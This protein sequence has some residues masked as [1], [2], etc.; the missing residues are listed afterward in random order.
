MNGQRGGALI[1]LGLRMFGIAFVLD[2]LRH[3]MPPVPVITPLM[4]TV[5]TVLVFGAVVNLVVYF[6]W[7]WGGR[8][9]REYQAVT[10]KLEEYRGPDLT[11][12]ELARFRKDLDQAVAA[13]RQLTQ[14]A[15][16]IRQ[17]ML[18]SSLSINGVSLNGLLPDEQL[19][20]LSGEA[21]IEPVLGSLRY[22]GPPPSFMLTG[23]GPQRKLGQCILCTTMTS[24]IYSG[25]GP[26][27][28]MCDL[29]ARQ[30]RP[31]RPCLACGEES[32][33]VIGGPEPQYLCTWH[34]NHL[35][36]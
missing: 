28:Y 9:E 19:A 17:G 6:A 21:V 22:V 27:Y 15:Q 7:N 23:T 30:Q 33:V 36:A 11:S 16:V 2:V 31:L 18:G 24:G 32:D 20:V 35:G 8:G 5:S 4:H 13:G 29:H 26:S 25:L 12:A 10:A 1:P 3:L 14:A 34:A